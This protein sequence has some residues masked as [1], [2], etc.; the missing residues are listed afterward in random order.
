MMPKER[1][2]VFLARAIV[3]PQ[4]DLISSGERHFKEGL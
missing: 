4:R 1:T 2:C 3:T